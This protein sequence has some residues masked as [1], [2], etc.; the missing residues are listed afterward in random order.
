MRKCCH[1]AEST[2]AKCRSEQ[3]SPSMASKRMK[4]GS[5]AERHAGT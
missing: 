1:G 2:Q 4:I 3:K 5:R